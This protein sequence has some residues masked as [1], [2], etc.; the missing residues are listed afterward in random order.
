MRKKNRLPEEFSWPVFLPFC[1]WK[2]R[3]HCATKLVKKIIMQKDVE[4]TRKW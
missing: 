1:V 4:L 3:N 2:Y